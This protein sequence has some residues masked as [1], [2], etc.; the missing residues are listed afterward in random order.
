[1][2]LNESKIKKLALDYQEAFGDQFPYRMVPVDDLQEWLERCLRLKKDY[3]DIQKL[4]GY[5]QRKEDA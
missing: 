4:A 5:D 1:M 3:W 2:A